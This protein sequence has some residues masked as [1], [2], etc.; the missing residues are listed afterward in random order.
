MTR[1]LVRI[2][3]RATNAYVLSGPR[4]PTCGPPDGRSTPLSIR[5]PE[6]DI[7]IIDRAADLRGRSRTDFVREAAVRAAEEVLMEPTLI[8]MSPA[9]SCCL[10]RR[11][12]SAR[13]A[14]RGDGRTPASVCTLLEG[15]RRGAEPRWRSL[16]RSFGGE[17]L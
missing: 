1:H 3:S 8:H 7:A 6:V 13:R 9:G 17:R 15:P 5:L 12:R 10:P 4:R 11:D 2:A 16:P 14:R